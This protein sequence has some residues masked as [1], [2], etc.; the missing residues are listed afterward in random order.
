[1]KLPKG[2]SKLFVLVFVLQHSGVIQEEKTPALFENRLNILLCVE[3][4]T[5]AQSR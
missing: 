2:K 5:S 3:Q 4:V 1:M